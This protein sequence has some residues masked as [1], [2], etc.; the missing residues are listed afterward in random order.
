MMGYIK[1]RW[2]LLDKN[3]NEVTFFEETEGSYFVKI[4]S[5]KGLVVSEKMKVVMEGAIREA[6]FKLITNETFIKLVQEK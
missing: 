6:Q 2:A 1:M 5:T 4:T 3:T